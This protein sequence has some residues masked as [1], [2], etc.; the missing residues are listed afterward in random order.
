MITP[1]VLGSLKTSHGHAK[2]HRIK[3]DSMMTPLVLVSLKTSHGH[4]KTHGIKRDVMITP[5]VLGSLKTT[6]RTCENTQKF[7]GFDEFTVGTLEPK[8]PPHE[9]AKT[10]RIKRDVMITPLVLGS[11]KTSHEYSEPHGIKQDS[12]MKPLVLGS[13]KTP[14]EHAKTHGI[15]QDSMMKPLVIGV[16]IRTPSVVLGP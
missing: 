7:A 14:H 4:A 10:H 13:L 5:F 6:T 16:T 1:F 15:K 9:H 8:D 3:Q 2:T 11:L 12:M